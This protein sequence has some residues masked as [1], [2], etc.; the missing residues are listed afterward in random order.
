MD[1]AQ[2]EL[3]AAMGSNPI[4]DRDDHIEVVVI[5]LIGLAIRGSFCKICINCLPAGHEQL[6]GVSARG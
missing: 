1:V 2:R 5:D 4:A 3:G 6:A